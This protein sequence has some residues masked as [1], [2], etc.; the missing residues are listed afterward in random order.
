MYAEYRVTKISQNNKK[1]QMNQCKQVSFDMKL[2]VT[3]THT[4]NNHTQKGVTQRGGW[5]DA[6]INEP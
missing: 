2:K 6:A 5:D 4:L 3:N 1:F